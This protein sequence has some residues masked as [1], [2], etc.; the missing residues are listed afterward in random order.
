[1]TIG[2]LNRCV[3]LDK[4]ENRSIGRREERGQDRFTF[5]CGETGLVLLMI[6]SNR[7]F[8]SFRSSSSFFAFSDRSRWSRS[9]SS[10]CFRSSSS[11]CWAKRN[12]SCRLSSFSRSR[13]SIAFLKRS[14]SA[15]RCS[16]T[17]RI[18]SCSRWCSSRSICF[19]RSSSCCRSSSRRCCASRIFRVSFRWYS[20]FWSTASV[21]SSAWLGGVDWPELVET[22]GLGGSPMSFRRGVD[23]NDCDVDIWE[24]ADGVRAE[25]GGFVC[26]KDRRDVGGGLE[27]GKWR[28]RVPKKN[29]LFVLMCW[30][31]VELMLEVDDW[32]VTT[33]LELFSVWPNGKSFLVI[34]V[35]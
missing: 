3:A 5:D 26:D 10:A 32:I 30:K 16:S 18:C 21:W 19:C 15:C 28:R 17:N 22:A 35:D 7:F 31:Q 4:N 14:S 33:A 13:S 24:R 9:A 25:R 29:E 1:M 6:R 8:L 2:D 27:R 23:D 20:S 12:S 11:F 34:A